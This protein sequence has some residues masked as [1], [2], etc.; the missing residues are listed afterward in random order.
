MVGVPDLNVRKEKEPVPSM[1]DKQIIIASLRRVERRIRANRLFTELTLGATFFL[2]IPLLLKLWDLVEPLR[3]VTIGIIG[4]IWVL[5]FGAFAVWRITQK[6]TLQEAAASADTRANLSDE[7][8][9]AFWFIHNPRPSEWVDAQIRRAARNARNLNLDRLY[10][11]QIP[12]T[13]YIAA[14][15]IVLFV[16]LNFVP[17]PWN[18]NWLTLQAA[19]AFALTD[20]EEAILKQTEELL[21]KAEKLKNS[22]LAAQVEDIVEQ[23]KEGKIDAQQA[24]QMLDQIQSQLEEGN[25]DTASI[26]EGLEEMAKDLQQAEQLEPTANAMEGKQLN[27]AADE[28][29]KLAEKLGLNKPEASKEMQKSLQQAA[30]NS[31][32]GLEE[33]AKLLKEAAE[34]LKNEQQQLAQE[35][36]DGAAQ[37]LENIQQK[38]DS[39][40]LKNMASQQLQN[41]KDSLQQRQQAGQKGAKGQQQ[42]SGKGQKSQGQKPEAGQPPDG[43]S[44]SAESGTDGEPTD[45]AGQQGQPGA[46]MPGGSEGTGLMPGGKGGSDAPREGAPTSLQVQLQQQK[47]EGMQDGGEKPENLEESSK[48]ERSRLDYR[49]VKSD[50]SPAQK[51]LLNQDRIPWEYRPLIK[52]YFQAIRPTPQKQDKQ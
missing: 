15:M 34:N 5:L 41:L 10:P 48:Q 9:T 31:R 27:L 32:P 42:A 29:R 13:F 16:S 37:E 8:K 39:Q 23:L 1:S 3:G 36:L 35:A 33:L 50:L 20:K 51:D 26:N 14:G 28:L 18:H 7:L 2:T 47:V 6:G 46:M 38:I 19:P 24:A 30:E 12:R 17:L 43:E 49:N 40:Q 52:D 25:L 21:R 11:R 45:Q 22:E 44:Q 4:G